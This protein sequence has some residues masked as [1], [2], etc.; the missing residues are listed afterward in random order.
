VRGVLLKK[1]AGHTCCI[2]GGGLVPLLMVSTPLVQR[3][4]PKSVPG[5]SQSVSLELVVLLHIRN[6]VDVPEAYSHGIFRL[7]VQRGTLPCFRSREYEHGETR[8]IHRGSSTEEWHATTF[9]RAFQTG[10]GRAN[11]AR[12]CV[13]RQCCAGQW[14]QYQFA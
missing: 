3:R 4:N 8:A 11:I 5:E 1:E 7:I 9:L 12:R 13:D 14:P 10:S 6:N 2:A